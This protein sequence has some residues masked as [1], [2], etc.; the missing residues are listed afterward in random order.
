MVP[1]VTMIRMNITPTIAVER[2]WTTKAITMNDT[3][4]ISP[5]TKVTLKL[6]V[7]SGDPNTSPPL[8]GSTFT[9]VCGLGIEGLTAF[10]KELQG[11]SCG[12][13]TRVQI[14][15]QC[16]EL[17]FEHLARS[18]FAVVQIE[19]PIDL[20]IEVLSVKPVSGRELVKALK[21]KTEAG[22]SGC[23]CGCR[24]QCG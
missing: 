6:A 24:C 12:D 7:I 3:I 16:E 9:F 13:R 2:C 10:E 5:L 18:V 1:W 19:P 11:L 23:G 15:S 4:S 14:D 20:S 17:Y 8:K 22:S 21:E